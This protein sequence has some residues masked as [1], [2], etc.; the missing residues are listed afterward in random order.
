MSRMTEQSGQVL[1]EMEDD[2]KDYKPLSDTG[3]AI[4]EIKMQNPQMKQKAIAEKVG[5]TVKSVSRIIRSDEF[6][7]QLKAYRKEVMGD[8]YAYAMQEGF[9]SIVKIFQDEEEAGSVKVD[10]FKAVSGLGG[11]GQQ[12]KGGGDGG[13]TVNVSSM[14]ITKDMIEEANA[15]RQKR[16]QGVTVDEQGNEVS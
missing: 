1:A 7:Y 10:A 8:S 6:Q 11:Y 3:W 15:R 12:K 5:I 14:G 9:K 16:I 4:L 13:V 2:E